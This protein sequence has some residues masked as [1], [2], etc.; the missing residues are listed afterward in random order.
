MKTSELSSVSDSIRDHVRDTYLKAA[1]RKG[2]ESFTVNVGSVHRALRLESKK[3][4]EENKLRIISKTGPPSGQS[5][6][7][8]FTYEILE[9][10]GKLPSRDNPLN[11]LRGIAKDIFSELGGGET[12]IRSER[13]QF[14][15]SDV[16][17]R[18][19]Q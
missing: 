3:L 7:V 18:K 2:D 8:T 19:H 11:G 14:A 12:F 4:L 16:P 9:P 13:N 15:G 1:Q 17:K 10:G 5:T 6:T